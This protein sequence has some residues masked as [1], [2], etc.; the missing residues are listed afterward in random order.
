[1][2]V[3]G[4]VKKVS[5]HQEEQIPELDVFGARPTLVCHSNFVY[6]YVCMYMYIYICQY[7]SISISLSVYLSISTCILRLV[8]KEIDRVSYKAL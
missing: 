4:T 2:C 7:Q 3:L 8:R 6:M 5:V 1:M